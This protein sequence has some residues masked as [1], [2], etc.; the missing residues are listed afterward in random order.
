MPKEKTAKEEAEQVGC[1]LMLVSSILLLIVMFGGKYLY[2]RIEELS[3][4]V[5]MLEEQVDG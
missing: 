4:R 2:D 3:N 5:D 1:A